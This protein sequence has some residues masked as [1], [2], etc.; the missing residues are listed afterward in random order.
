M[1]GLFKD[2][3]MVEFWKY[4]TTWKIILESVTGNV[5]ISEVAA[6][7]YVVLSKAEKHKSYEE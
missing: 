6:V 2:E 7:T 4:T 3:E 5:V 1:S